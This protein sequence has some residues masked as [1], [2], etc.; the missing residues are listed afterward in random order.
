[1]KLFIQ[2]P[3]YNEEKTI[4][5]TLADLPKNLVGFDSVEVLII[6]DGSS[7]DTVKVAKEFGV[8]HFVQL[9]SNQGLAKGFMLGLN[10]CL[11]NGADVIINTDA[12]NQYNADDISK[13]TQPIIDKKAELVIGARP[14]TDIQHFSLLKKMLQ[15]LG[16]WVVRVVSNTNIADAPS[17]FR[18]ISKNAAKQMNVFNDYTYTLETIIQAG[19]KKISITSVPIRTNADLRKSKLVKSTTFYLRRSVIT[20]LRIFVVY[21]PFAF[22]MSIGLFLF[23]IGLVLGLRFI[24]FYITGDGDGH[25]QSVIL[26]AIFITVG[27]NTGL[28]AFIADLL[29]VNRKL[30]E[31]IKINTF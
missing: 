25:I 11:K 22:F 1:M 23:I 13:L 19:Q 26:S 12:D 5:I 4:G 20:I 7:D 15:K 21:K 8:K 6:D 18:A 31:D 2:I 28:I 14:I 9:P 16:S 3:C 17:G 10:Y 24:Y 29:A 27:F 30:L